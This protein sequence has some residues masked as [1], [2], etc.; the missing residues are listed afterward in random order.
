MRTHV[1]EQRRDALRAR[2][3]A[4]AKTLRGEISAALNSES[5][6]VPADDRESADA[7]AS[8]SA[9]SIARDTDELRHIGQALERMKTGSYGL[10]VD[11]GTALPMTRLEASPEAGRCI[12][13]ENEHERG[14]APPRL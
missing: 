2:L 3:E 6:R 14:R 8:V 11:C 10:C 9:A 12:R 13:C 1:E 5:L 4:R 7:T